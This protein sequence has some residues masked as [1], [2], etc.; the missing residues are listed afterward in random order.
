MA[1]ALIVAQAHIA[2][3]TATATQT[4]TVYLTAPDPAGL[5]RL[6]RSA[7]GTVTGSPQD[8]A[9]RLRAFLPSRATHDTVA[10]KLDELGLRVIRST[11]WS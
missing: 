7:A 11:T 10:N 9:A 8:R 4:V 6:A 5:D 2:T 1:L 3:A